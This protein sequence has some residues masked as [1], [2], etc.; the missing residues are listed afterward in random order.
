MASALGSS[1][2]PSAGALIMA[3]YLSHR[4]LFERTGRALLWGVAVFG[5]SMI[6]FPLSTSFVLSFVLLAVSGAADNISV[7]VRASI[8]QALTPNHLRGRVS[9]VNGVFVGSSNEIGAFESGV[10]ARWFGTVP[11]VV[12]GGVLTLVVVAVT[13]WRNP[14]L[15]RLGR[16]E[17]LPPGA[18]ASS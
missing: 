17:P 16:M 5:C 15:R 11:S 8:L 18:T 6:V 10:T 2:A 14:T 9:S 7:V 1:A 4:A 13:A 3:L 12:L